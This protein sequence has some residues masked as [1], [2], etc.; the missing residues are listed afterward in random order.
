MSADGSLIVGYTSNPPPQGGLVPSFWS[1]G[2][3]S[4]LA[5]QGMDGIARDISPNGLYVGGSTN[6]FDMNTFHTINQATLWVDDDLAIAA[7]QTASDY[8]MVLLTDELGNP[9]DGEVYAVSDNGYAVGKSNPYKPFGQKGFIWHESFAGVRLFDEW[10]LAEYGITLPTPSI[11]INDVFFDG[12]NLSFAV[13]GSAYFVTVPLD[14][15]PTPPLSSIAGYVYLDANDNGVMDATESGL[16]GV[17]IVLSGPVER[18]VLTDADGAY[19][20]EALPDGVYAVSQVQPAGYLD[21]IDTQGQPLLGSVE[22]DRFFDLNLSDGLELV[23]YNFGERP[24]ANSTNSV[25]GLVYIDVNNN[26]QRDA[27]ELA[28]PNVAISING[29]VQRT[30]LTGMDGTYL[31]ADL[32]DGIYTVSQSQPANFL[33]GLNTPGQP[34]LGQVEQNRFVDLNLSGGTNA[35]NYNFGERGVASP[36]KAQFL[37][38]TPALTPLT[39]AH[40]AGPDAGRWF[41]LVS[42][43][44]AALNVLADSG[45]AAIELYTEAMYPVAKSEQGRLQVSVTG[46]A[47]YLLRLNAESEGSPVIEMAPLDLSGLR[48][49]HRATEPLDVSGDGQVRPLDVLLIVNELNSRRLTDAQGRFLVH[50][51]AGSTLPQF[52]VNGDGRLT[53]LDALMVVNGLNGRLGAEG[54]SSPEIGRSPAVYWGSSSS[55]L[56]SHKR[57]NRP[58][59]RSIESA[60]VEE[61]WADMPRAR[62]EAIAHELSLTH[63]QAPRADGDLPWDEITAEPLA[64][65]LPIGV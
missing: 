42:G 10:L 47:P 18:T 45:T 37:A 17:S 31:F 5:T 63:L 21:G 2:A 34:A 61:D 46:G 39:L 7:D 43:E 51:A 27:A 56:A 20:F 22:N 59:D 64:D 1:G 19:R 60:F 52:D 30:T 12:L 3:L 44:D 35:S 16:A 54:E 65:L 53:A 8:R 38:S 49:F 36:S 57:P 4:A 50:P 32:P 58:V 40:M 33:D 15:I 26:G 55:G 23:D 24:F 62:V 29:P 28:L 9:F 25:S 13:L 11:A 48:G 41:S 6:F 14:G